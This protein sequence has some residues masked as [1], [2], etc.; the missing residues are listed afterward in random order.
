VHYDPATVFRKFV[1]I[2]V[3]LLKKTSSK[4]ARSEDLGAYAFEYV[5][6]PSS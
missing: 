3:R 1:S 5:R 4:A 6:S 2:P